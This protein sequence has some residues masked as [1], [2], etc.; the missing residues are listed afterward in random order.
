MRREKSRKLWVHKNLYY[1]RMLFTNSFSNWIKQEVE[2]G[3]SH[4]SVFVCYCCFVNYY[5]V[6]Q[7]DLELSIFLFQSPK[8]WNCRYVSAHP[9]ELCILLCRTCG[10]VK[11]GPPCLLHFHPRLGSSQRKNSAS[12]CF[13]RDVKVTDHYVHSEDRMLIKYLLCGQKYRKKC[14]TIK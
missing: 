13:K 8:C 1:S 6:V 4:M 2:I 7:D 5:Y 3:R 14:V 11:T 9:W 10:C 12:I